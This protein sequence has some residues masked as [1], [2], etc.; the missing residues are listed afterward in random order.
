LFN[1][2]SRSSTESSLLKFLKEQADC[3]KALPDAFHC[4]LVDLGDISSFKDLADAVTDD[5]Y[6]HDVLHQN[7]LKGFKHAAFKKAILV[8]TDQC[9]NDVCEQNKENE[10]QLLPSWCAHYLVFS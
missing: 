6:L 9:H 1:G 3:L 7:G 5:Q 2:A 10:R 8:A 4:W